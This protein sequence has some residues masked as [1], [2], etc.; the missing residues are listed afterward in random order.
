MTIVSIDA[1][2]DRDEEQ[3]ED[4][5]EGKFNVILFQCE[6]SEEQNQ[7]INHTHYELVA[8]KLCQ[9]PEDSQ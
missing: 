9:R 5:V 1:I 8:D 4:E 7:V 2:K 3:E 6:N